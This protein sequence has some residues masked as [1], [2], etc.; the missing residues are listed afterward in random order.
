MTF[1]NVQK[2]YKHFC[3]LAEG[4]FN[5]RDFDRTSGTNEGEAEEGI[6]LQGKMTPQRVA[7]IKSNALR[8][9]LDAEKKYPQLLKQ[10][11]EI[12][13]VE[14]QKETKSKEKK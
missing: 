12:K 9:K 4:K 11:Q 3:K 5:E 13:P 6:T 2:L 1:E 14:V 10:V 8:H 7:L